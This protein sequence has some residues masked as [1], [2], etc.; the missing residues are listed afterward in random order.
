[1]LNIQRSYNVPCIEHSEECSNCEASI[2]WSR[3]QRP[4]IIVLCGSTKFYEEFMQVMAEETLKG[5]IVISVG[6][7]GHRK[8]TNPFEI[9]ITPEVKQM[10][11]TL[12]FRKID[13]ADE[14]RIINPNGYIGFSTKREIEYA[15][16]LAKLVTY[17]SPVKEQTP[18]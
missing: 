6:L 11:D 18:A 17:Y 13:L 9:E 3:I 12:H 15:R 14:V 8:D 1:M 4:K 2:G 7:F 5:N 10:L 16:R